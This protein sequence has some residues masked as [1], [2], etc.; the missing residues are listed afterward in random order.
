MKIRGFVEYIFYPRTGLRKDVQIQ[1]AGLSVRTQTKKISCFGQVPY[2]TQGDYLEFDGE[3]EQ[4]GK[5]FKFTIASRIDDDVYGASSMLVYVLGPKSASSVVHAFDDNPMKA[6]EMFKEH[7]DVFADKALQIKGI[8]Q[9]KLTK[10]FAKYENHIAVDVLFSRFSKYG[11]TL[12]KALSIYE[13]WGDKT[14]DILQVNPYRLVALD[15]LPFR[16]VDNIA[17]GYYHLEENDSRRIY[18]G[19]LNILLGLNMQ[20]HTFIRLDSTK[21]DNEKSLIDCAKQLLQVDESLIREELFN[22]ADEK[23]IIMDKFGFSTIVYLPKVY[24]AEKGIAS[25]VHDF[26]AQNDIEDEKINSHIQAYEMDKGFTMADKQKEAVRMAVKNKLSIISGPPGAGKT[27]IID[28]ICE[29]LKAERPNVRIR[30]A[31]P[32]GKAAKRMSESTGMEAETVHRMLKFSPQTNAFTFDANNPL[33]AD[34]VIVDEFSM[35]SM[36]LTYQLLQAIPSYC[37]VILVGDKNQLPSVD[38]G[39]VLEDMLNTYYIP[40]VILNKIYR[41]GNDSTI[42]T[43]AIDISND[44]LPDLSDAKD[45]TFWEESDVEDLREGLLDLYYS[46]CQTY[47]RE[48][49]LLL[50]PM[51]KG[52]LGVDIL[53][54]IIQETINPQKPGKLEIKT[55]KRY[56]RLHDRVIQLK[57]EEKFDVFNGMVGEIIEIIPEDKLNGISEC[58]V[59]DFGDGLTCEY[60]RDRYENLKLAYAMTVHKCQGSEASSVILICHSLHKFMLRKKLVY[61]GMT[62]AKKHLHIVGEKSMFKY[63]L[64]NPEPIRNTKLKNF[65]E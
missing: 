48:N 49:V 36:M 3:W 61:T 34:V 38:A 2:I 6:W 1:F 55:G 8:G 45:F 32:T 7:P 44:L 31:A 41:Q 22:L 13:A 10:A 24:K 51:N 20:G 9:K 56:F 40:K 63:S 12:N 64:E 16:T 50:T 59:V 35:M 43:R 23:K 65:L 47:G 39:K 25:I 60:T 19:V 17:R 11:L 57:N 58:L 53:N 29:L 28:C 4:D 26:I 37:M 54:Q 52:E 42:L 46:E 33:E 15:K 30:L 27:T 14:L 21:H 62:R 18:A 5:S